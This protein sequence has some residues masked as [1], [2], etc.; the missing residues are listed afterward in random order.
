[1]LCSNKN[2]DVDELGQNVYSLVLGQIFG[3]T[4]DRMARMFLTFRM[5]RDDLHI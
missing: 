4:H 1:M 2:L 3:C 5:S